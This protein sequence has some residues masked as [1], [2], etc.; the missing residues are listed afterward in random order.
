[1]GR[2]S[3]IHSEGHWAE[4]RNQIPF[5]KQSKKTKKKSIKVE[6]MTETKEMC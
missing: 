4:S 1:M 5:A 6:L 3:A 2:I